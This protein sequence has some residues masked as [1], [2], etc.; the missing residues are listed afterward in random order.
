M[1]PTR[2]HAHT[3]KRAHTLHN[4]VAE[5]FSVTT[6]AAQ[7]HTHSPR[8]QERREKVRERLTLLTLK[9]KLTYKYETQVVLLEMSLKHDNM[10]QHG[11]D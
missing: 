3:H 8:N 10:K 4:T 9:T 5:A 11:D 2:M 7:A 6:R 1:K